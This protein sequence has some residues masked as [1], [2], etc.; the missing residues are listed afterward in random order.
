MNGP[1][2]GCA[3]RGVSIG[4]VLGLV[5]LGLVVL[6]VAAAGGCERDAH[7]GAAPPPTKTAQEQ[8]P[9]LVRVWT[10]GTVTVQ[11]R[12]RFLA[13]VA[14]LR[15]T[16]ISPK[17][18]G[19]IR[20]ITKRAGD[21]VTKDEVLVELDRTDY[22]LAV[23]QAQ[24]QLGVARAAVAQA[25]EGKRAAGLPLERFRKL[26]AAGSVPDAEF[27]RVEA[28]QKLAAKGHDA[29]RAQAELAAVGLAAAE[30][31]LS[32]TTVR[33]PFDG[34]V[35]QRLVDEG[36]VARAMPPTIVLVVVEAP[37]YYVEGAVNELEAA[38]ITVGT[39]LDVRVHALPDVALKA[40]VTHVN[41]MVDPQTRT[42]A[43]RALVRDGVEPLKVGM[44]A[45]ATADMGERTSVFVPRVA[46]LDREGDRA[47]AYVVDGDRAEK[48]AVRLGPVHRDGF[49]VAEGLRA[50][51][52]VV[53]AGQGDIGPDGRVQG[54]ADGKGETGGGGETGG[55]GKTGVGGTR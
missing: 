51:E 18:P 31:Q 17:I 40:D 30:Q 38:R 42:V 50:G 34:F 9:A 36:E 23:R 12:V 21:R 15:Q 26:K 32:D 1:A 5:V 6:A 4:V 37:P 44:S 2:S 43:I 3:S 53:V 20:S 16:M 35:V 55:Q 7:P 25:L 52:V 41:A 47:A 19:T 10:I 28:Q 46:L 45:E 49:L 29:A 54:K 13:T 27:D 24:A 22:D 33:A 8:R 11:D 39:P 14:P 48:R